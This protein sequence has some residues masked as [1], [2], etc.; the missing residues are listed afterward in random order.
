MCVIVREVNVI[1]ELCL[2]RDRE[3]NRGRGREK[4][5]VREKEGNRKSV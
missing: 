4:K 2:K 3:A 1:G 5:R